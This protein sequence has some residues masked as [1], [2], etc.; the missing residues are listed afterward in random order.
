MHID[1]SELFEITLHFKKN[2]DVPAT[3]SL[4]FGPYQIR[5]FSIRKTKFD[6]NENDYYLCPPTRWVRG[7]NYFKLFWAD[8]EEWEKLE[9][10]VL[11]EFARS[12]RVDDFSAATTRARV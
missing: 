1:Y 10:R 2:K 5:G 6:D 9:K 7:G 3:V 11:E 8:K 12:S 4:S